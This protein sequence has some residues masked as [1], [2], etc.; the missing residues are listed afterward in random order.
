MP[1]PSAT[2]KSPRRGV[3]W[4]VAL[5]VLV[6][7]FGA[8]WHFSRSPGSAKGGAGGHGRNGMAGAGATPVSVATVK[9]GRIETT[10]KAIGTVTALNTVTVLS[11]V[12][13][14]LDRVYFTEGQEVHKGDLLAQIDPRPY[15]VAL[16]QAIGTQKQNQA[17]LENAQRD[18]KRYQLLYKQ[19]SLA[20]Q[21]LDT[22]KAL[23]QQYQGTEKSDAAAVAN[24][25]LQLSFTRITSPIT[26]V[27]GL[28]QVD[29][30]NLISASGTTGLVVVTQMQPISVIFAL[31]QAQLP[32]VL[33]EVRAG[34]KLQVD[35]YDRSGTNKIATG[36]L[37]SI[38][39][40]IDVTTGTVKLRA[41]FANQSEALFPNEFVNAVLHVSADDHAVM[42]PTAAL[43]QGSIG[44]FVYLL[45][46]GK[47]HV[48]PVKTGT[49]DGD[50]VAVSDGLS[51]G[52]QVVTVGVDRLREG[53]AVK[54]IAPAAASA[55]PTGQAPVGP[56]AAVN[57]ATPTPA[58]AAPSA[59]APAGGAAKASPAK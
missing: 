57:P 12:S 42:I 21:Q 59:A 50:N 56:D 31:S 49:V 10:I 55:T 13:G 5:L 30:G 44:A 4:A 22:Q 27:V 2:P 1:Q 54:I 11:R 46:D 28:R 45:K 53:A 33:E 17:Q 9:Q 36:T 16:D 40:Q 43:Q 58:P 34:R 18:L 51:P 24:A 52:Q 37:T 23:V 20:G 15:Q 25:R 39:N 32:Q 6:V 14:E 3:A 47:V 7:A 38:D 26:G 35:L 19:S 41:T 8:Y 48:Q 29:P